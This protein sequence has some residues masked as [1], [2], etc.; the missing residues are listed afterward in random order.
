[1]PAPSDLPDDNDRVIDPDVDLH[2]AEQRSEIR[3][4]E[5]DVLLA[6]ALGG[7]LGAWARYAVTLALP[8]D[9]GEFA[10]STVLVN[11]SGCLLIGV[12]M[13][14]LLELGK[15]H[16]LARPFLGVG[17]LG[18]YTTYSSFA[19]D[20]VTLLREHRP[21]VAAGYVVVTVV[22]CAAAVWL[23]TTATLSAVRRAA[24]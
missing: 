10:W 8:H 9:P 12:L 21:G 5:W 13:V 4:H 19:V 3:P 11:V 22:M 24:A 17:V 2:V 15:P 6:C 7:I 16:R 14:V 23:A 1:M 18:G 20:A